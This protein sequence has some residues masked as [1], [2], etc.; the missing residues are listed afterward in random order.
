MREGIEGLTIRDVANAASVG[1]GSVYLHFESRDHLLASLIADGLARSKKTWETRLAKR[2]RHDL[3]A[4]AETYVEA[5][6]DHASLFEATVRLRLDLRRA[7]LPPSAAVELRRTIDGVIAPFEH[8]I[9][10]RQ[11]NEPAPR[12]LGAS[13]WAALNGVILTFAA[14]PGRN[15]KDERVFLLGQARLIAE[16]FEAR[17]PDTRSPSGS[18]P[19]RKG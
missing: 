12:R 18:K 5:I 6:L 10:A 13:L 3:R 9:V 8:A 19:R 11:P 17:L 1:V 16:A 2:G 15:P 14:E 4:L 7:Q